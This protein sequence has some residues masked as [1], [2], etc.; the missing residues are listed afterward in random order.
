MGCGPFVGLDGLGQLLFD[1]GPQNLDGDLPAVGRD[2]AVN[3]RD[4]SRADRLLVKFGIQAVER[5]SE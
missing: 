3:L 5:C 1:P 2:G 4:G